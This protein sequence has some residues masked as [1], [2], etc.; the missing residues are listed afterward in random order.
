MLRKSSG[1]STWRRDPNTTWWLTQMMP[2]VTKLSANAAKLGHLSASALISE[3]VPVGTLRSSTSRVMA[4]AK[5]PSLNA[6]RRSVFIA[7]G[8]R[9]RLAQD[10][11]QGGDR[12]RDVVVTVHC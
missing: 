10:G 9:R 4:T 11:V 8:L 2:M 7:A 12:E 6:S 1:R 5:T 3:P